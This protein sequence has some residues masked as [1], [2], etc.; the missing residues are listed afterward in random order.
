MSSASNSLRRATSLGSPPMISRSVSTDVTGSRNM[1][2][3]FF[4]R[5]CGEHGADTSPLGLAILPRPRAR[6]Q[7]TAASPL[8]RENV[9]L[10]APHAREVGCGADGSLQIG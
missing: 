5:Q 8:P 4:S 9:E 6:G 10:A 2:L 3:S 1:G 7:A